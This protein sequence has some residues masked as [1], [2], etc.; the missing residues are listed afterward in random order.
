MK[1][2]NIM[3]VEDDII[4]LKLLNVMLKKNGLV[5]EIIEASNGLDGIEK[6]KNNKVDLVLL[7]II[8]PIMDGI[9]MLKI[10]KSDDALKD[11]PVIVLSTDETKRSE[12][13]ENGANDFLNK[14]IR[15][16]PLFEKIK[17][18]ISL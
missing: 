11:I 10:I 4:N 16:Q 5:K 1:K 14:P 13:L 17:T 7:D 2:F 9:E 15:E 3:I 6:L 12:A 18:Y 8:M